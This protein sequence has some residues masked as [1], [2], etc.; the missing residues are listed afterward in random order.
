LFDYPIFDVPEDTYEGA[1]MPK[2]KLKLL[3]E[4]AISK[5]PERIDV[6]KNAFERRWWIVG[7]HSRILVSLWNWVCEHTTKETVSE[8]ELDAKTADLS[9]IAKVI[10]R[11]T[12][13]E[14]FTDQTESLLGDVSIYLGELLKRGHPELFWDVEL[15]AKSSVDYGK[16]MLSGFKNGYSVNLQ[17]V[18]QAIRWRDEEQGHDAERLYKIYLRQ[19]EIASLK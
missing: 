15:K 3:N 9:P 18:L 17:G 5:F 2:K 14:T 10:A 12:M 6:L 7:H 11:H 16:I 1:K 8:E 19:P 4:W 13:K